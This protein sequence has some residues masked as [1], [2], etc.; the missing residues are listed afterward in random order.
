MT[1]LDSLRYPIGPF[2]I[3]DHFSEEIIEDW[4]QQIATL[5]TRLRKEVEQLNDTQLDS[6]YRPEGWT[7]RQV[8][9]HLADSHM[10]ALLRFKLT[11]TEDNP[12]IKPYS[13]Q[14]WAELVDSKTMPITPALSIVEGVHTRLVALL[15]AMSE[16]DFERSY[17]H[18]QYQREYKLKEVL[19]LYAWHGNHHLAHITSIKQTMGWA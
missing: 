7:I 9:N 8:V 14:L 2:T 15:N 1:N 12:V 10:N 13:E 6:P 16:E 18:P 11:L 19:A 4:I 17:I 5:P 3:P